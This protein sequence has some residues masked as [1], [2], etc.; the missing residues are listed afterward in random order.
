MKY[1]NKEALFTFI[2]DEVVR[3]GG[4]DGEGW[5][6]LKDTQAK[7]MAEEFVEWIKR[8]ERKFSSTINEHNSHF[9]VW[10]DQEGFTFTN[11]EYDPELVKYADVAIQMY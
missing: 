7:V 6:F 1:T 3:S 10:D 8:T 9:Y 2:F 5:I 4:G 11:A